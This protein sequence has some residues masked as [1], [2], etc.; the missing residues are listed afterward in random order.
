[1]YP[2]SDTVTK[3]RYSFQRWINI[4]RSEYL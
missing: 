2:T 4:F 3:I 1:L